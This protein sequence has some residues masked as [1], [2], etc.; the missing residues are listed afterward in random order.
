MQK[1]DW[2]NSGVQLPPGWHEAVAVRADELKLTKRAIYVAAVHLA[3]RLPIQELKAL[4]RE[5]RDLGD[6]DFG[7]LVALHYPI[8]AQQSA[9]KAAPQRKPP[10]E[11]SDAELLHRTGKT[12]AE[13]AADVVDGPAAAEAAR[14]RRKKRG[15]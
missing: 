10:H 6:D 7:A 12:A 11:W 1:N 4:A 9:S 14:Q 13:H 5:L 3:L 8:A 2:Q 15:A